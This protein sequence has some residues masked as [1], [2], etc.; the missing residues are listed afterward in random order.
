MKIV[1]RLRE[2]HG[3]HESPAI[4]A[5]IPGLQV[6]PLYE[7]L[8]GTFPNHEANPLKESNLDDLRAP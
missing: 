2:R 1:R 6:V 4:F 8:D 7:Q 3:R 5:R